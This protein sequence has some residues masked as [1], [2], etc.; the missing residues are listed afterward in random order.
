MVI[1]WRPARASGTSAPA[2]DLSPAETRRLLYHCSV[3]ATGGAEVGVG[4]I[5]ELAWETGPITVATARDVEMRVPEDTWVPWLPLV[6]RFAV[7]PANIR[8]VRRKVAP[9]PPVC[10]LRAANS[11][12][13]ALGD[14]AQTLTARGEAGVVSTAACGLQIPRCDVY[15]RPGRKS[16]RRRRRRRV[17]DGVAAVPRRRASRRRYLVPRAQALAWLDGCLAFERQHCELSDDQAAAARERRLSKLPPRG[18]PLDDARTL[19]AVVVP[20]ADDGGDVEAAAAPAPAS[21]VVAQL[22]RLDAAT[23]AIGGARRR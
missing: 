20:P 16:K 4:V 22:A 21:D 2:P 10:E 7:T 3:A 14:L 17:R 13:D 9:I 12:A 18:D 15:P 11:D 5:S 1:P 19:W 6:L 23:R 8:R